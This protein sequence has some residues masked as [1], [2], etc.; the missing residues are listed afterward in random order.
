MLLAPGERGTLMVIAADRRQARVVFRY[1]EGL[2]DEVPMLA[3]LV[4][5]RTREAIHL[6]NRVTIEVHTASFRAVRGYTLI[7]AIC[8][9]VA[10]WRAEESANPDVEIINA[11]RPGMATVPGALLLCIGS[12]Y[13]R[14]GALWE[15]Y[16]THYGRDGDPVLV[17]QADTRSMNTTSRGSP[18]A[19]H[20]G[21][22]PCPLPVR[23]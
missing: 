22:G 4:Q 1:V 8:D 21:T 7:G 13:A 6:T 15:A 3:A 12:P 23:R 17:W 5:S 10:Y 9:E 18:R 11:L 20:W 16:R 14:R 19:R 2:L